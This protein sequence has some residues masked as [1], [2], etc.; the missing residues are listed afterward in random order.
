METS[1][2]Y[3]RIGRDAWTRSPMPAAALLQ[4]IIPQIRPRFIS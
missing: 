4:R 1:W 2:R 3:A